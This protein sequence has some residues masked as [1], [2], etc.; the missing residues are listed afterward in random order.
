MALTAIT[1]ILPYDSGPES[2][3]A[4]SASGSEVAHKRDWTGLRDCSSVSRVNLTRPSDRDNELVKVA[5][6]HGPAGIL[7]VLRKNKDYG[8]FVVLAFRAVQMCLGPRGPSTLDQ[9]VLQACDPV[10]FA[11]QML[12]MEMID[13]ILQLMREYAGVRDLQHHGL[14]IIEILIMDDPEW[15]DEVARKGGVAI[16]CAI[17]KQRQYRNSP[18]IMC[19]VMTVM[20]YLAAEDYIEVMLCQHDAL[21]YV[22]YVL[23]FFAQNVE[24]ATRASLALLNLTV[25]ELHVE[26]MLEK[27]AIPL[28]LHVMDAHA[29]DVHLVI[30]LMGVLAN[31]SVREEV[32]HLLVQDRVLPRI[33]DAM[34]LDPSNAVLQV[35]C[36]KALV[37]Y[38]T[39]VEH[40]MIMD[41]L[42]IPLLVGQV[43]VDHAEDPGVQKYGNFFLGHHTSCPI[44]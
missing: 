21:Q 24:L 19:Q 1:P 44:L 12:E 27:R 30:I 18:S 25:C 3:H 13:D 5:A 26:E 37:N 17:A 4:L 2:P 8:W 31:Y 38:S 34:R 29:K 43:M 35:A 23:R 20:S 14:A 10:A 6:L 9:P 7:A 28:V 36:L 22:S 15:R 42:G 16:V 11:M 32:R 39:N 40:Y 41:E 33:A